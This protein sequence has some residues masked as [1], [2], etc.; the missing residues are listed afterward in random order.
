MRE[1]THEAF[2]CPSLCSFNIATKPEL[3]LTDDGA[4]ELYLDNCLRKRREASE[5]EP[6]YVWTN[7]E[8]E[9]EEHH[10]IEARYW[11]STGSSR[12]LLMVIR[13]RY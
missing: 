12:S 11:A 6:Q 7:V 10:H 3:K 8:L 5:R 13:C 4:I 2:P 1:P 9:W